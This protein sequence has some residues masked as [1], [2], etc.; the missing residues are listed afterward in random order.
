MYV[1]FA[2]FEVDKHQFQQL[3]ER[4]QFKNICNKTALKHV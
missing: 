2:K 3:I 1:Q 4:N